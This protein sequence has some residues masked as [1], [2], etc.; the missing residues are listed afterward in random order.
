[1]VGLRGAEGAKNF[2]MGICDGAPTI[3]RSSFNFNYPRTNKTVKI[4]D[5]SRRL[6][7]VCLVYKTHPITELKM[8]G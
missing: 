5:M 4:L 7:K 8:H 6:K 3:A 2:S 1:M